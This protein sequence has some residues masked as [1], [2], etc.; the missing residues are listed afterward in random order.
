M[1]LFD[2]I[3]GISNNIFISL[4]YRAFGAFDLNIK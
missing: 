4:I 3:K 2:K 1:K